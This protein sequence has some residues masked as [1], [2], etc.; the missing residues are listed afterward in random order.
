MMGGHFC[1]LYS[2]FVVVCAQTYVQ[3]GVLVC[4]QSITVTNSVLCHDN[5]LAVGA[6][7]YSSVPTRSG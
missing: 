7:S 4:S 5:G 2:L 3:R 6:R 1:G